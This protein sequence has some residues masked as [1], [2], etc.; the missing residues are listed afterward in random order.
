MSL[1]CTLAVWPW[2]ANAVSLDVSAHSP[3]MGVTK[4]TWPGLQGCYDSTSNRPFFR[5]SVSLII[6]VGLDSVTHGLTQLPNTD[7]EK[8]ASFFVLCLRREGLGT[9]C[10]RAP[11]PVPGL[12]EV[13]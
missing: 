8:T 9:D 6:K 1:P 2:S 11:A 12:W 5:S 3:K 7:Q 13:S 4:Y 10:L